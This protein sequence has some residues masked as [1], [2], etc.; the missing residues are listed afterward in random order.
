M[1]GRGSLGAGD[2]EADPGGGVYWGVLGLVA[3]LRGARLMGIDSAGA[4]P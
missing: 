4:V 1:L 3:D 2:V